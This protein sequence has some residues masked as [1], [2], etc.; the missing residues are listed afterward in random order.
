MARDS[1]EQSAA[2]EYT[3]GNHPRVERRVSGGPPLSDPLAHRE[4]EQARDRRGHQHE[5][6]RIPLHIEPEPV[7][8]ELRGVGAARYDEP[9]RVGRRGL[10][11][12]RLHHHPPAKREHRH[13][14]HDREAHQPGT[15]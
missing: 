3:R 11:P 8:G 7:E 10:G 4:R 12:G 5:V 2:H 14:D 13:A 1:H 6:R 15:P 9:E